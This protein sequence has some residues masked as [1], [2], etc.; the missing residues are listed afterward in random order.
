MGV[1]IFNRFLGA[2]SDGAAMFDVANAA[3]EFEYLWAENTERITRYE[4]YRAEQNAVRDPDLLL[5]TED[6]ADYGRSQRNIAEIRRH[7]IALPFGLA[8]TVKHAFRIAGELPDIIVDERAQ[9][10]VERHRSDCMEKIAW[11][12]IRASGDKQLFADGAWDGS[13]FGATCFDLWYHAS[14]GMPCIRSID[15]G[16]IMVVPGLDDPH[17]FQRVYRAWDVSL[18]SVVMDYEGKSFRGEAVKLNALTA[19]H[20]VEG[21]PLV[22]VIQMVDKTKLLRFAVGGSNQLIGLEEY[23]HDYGFVPYV[24]IPNIG[25]YRDI[26]GW[27]DYEFIRSIQHYLAALFSREAD[28]IRN[29]ANGSM[30]E[31]GTGQSPEAIATAI[32]TGGVVPSRKDGAIEPIEAPEMP[33]FEQNHAI[34]GMEMFKMLG[35][36]PDAAWGMPGSASGA[37]RGLQLQPL[38]EYTSM[39]QTNWQA[40]LQRLFSYVYRIIEQQP[41]K[42][43]TYRGSKPGVGGR[44]LAF[45]MEI[46]TE[47]DPIEEGGELTET[48]ELVGQETLHR[49]P[50]EIFDGEYVARFVWKNR[51]DPD[52]PGYVTSELAKFS[53]GAQS[54]ETTLAR[55]GVE[56]PEDEMRKIE[57]EAQRFPWINQ[58]MVSLLMAQLRGN[59]QG[60]GGGA[61]TDTAGA[62]SDAASEMAAGDM[63]SEADAALSTLPGASGAQYGF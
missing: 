2:D 17:D 15:P 30:I 42:K 61:P 23:S 5:S 48:G 54:L 50:A 27:A 44:S 38:I 31:K 8:L 9:T 56:A 13:R 57:E 10:S 49:S 11:A 40:G 41:P 35:F 20:S 62:M 33:T 53:Q 6:L 34:N 16:G 1:S 3:A 21:Q 26:W 36:A 51:V 14:K 25:L 18:Q 45:A 47:V 7:R 63:G 52:D 12:V 37:D 22:R 28:V 19:H 43:A 58:G 24:V 32:A 46:G 29:V 59:A 55:L 4:Q 39:K 60:L